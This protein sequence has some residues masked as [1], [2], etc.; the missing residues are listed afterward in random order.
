MRLEI[1]HFSDIHFQKAGNPILSIVDQLAQAVQSVDPAASL[2]LVVVSGDVAYSGSSAE[3]EIAL[4]FFKAFDE[5]LRKFAPTAVVKYVS[6]PGN[7]DCVLPKNG[8]K[9]REALIRGVIPSMREATQDKTLL[10]QL[11]KAQA[12][13]NRFRRRFERSAGWDGLCET[14]VIDHAGKKI[15]LNLYNTAILSQRDESQGN[16]HLPIQA[17]E[18]R[19]SLLK[20]SCVS[21][22]VFHHSY[23]WIESNAAVAF[24]NHVE[25]TSDIALMG[26]QHHAH[27]FYKENSTGERVL[28]L[29][30]PALQDE[31]FARTSS[32]QIVIIDTESQKERSIKFRRSRDLYRSV[33]ET[34]W[35][36]MT[37]NRTVRAQF[38]ANE[39]FEAELNKS[40][41]PLTHRTG[42]LHLRDTFI[43][44]NVLVRPAAN[45][46][47]TQEVNGKELLSYVST[48]RR[49]IFQGVSMSGK[50]ALAKVLFW[51]ILRAG[52]G[53][54]PVLFNGRHAT[55]PIEER[56][57]GEIWS[58]FSSQYDR[59]MLEE[60]KQ[61][62]KEDRVAII[63]DW[64]RTMLNSEGRKEFLNHIS[65]Y[66][67]K[68]IL[69]T[70]ELFQ[71]HEVIS[72]SPDTIIEFD[73]ANILEFGHSLVGRM[74]DKWVT[75][76]R[77]YTGDIRKIR[78]EIESK[79]R[80][81]QSVMGKK[82]LPALPFIV[83]SLLE[84]DEQDKAEAAE[85]GSF[86]Y[87]YEVLV[88]SALSQ[89][90]GPKAQLEKKYNVLARLAY[91]MF[92]MRTH[93][94]PLSTVKEIA[95]EYSKAILVT[96]DISSML[97]DLVEARVLINI[98]GNYS[99]AYS[100]FVYYF[101][102]R[103]YRD[104]LER[105]P[106]LHVEIEKMVDYV[107]SDEYSAILIFLV[108]FAR[109]STEILKRLGTNADMIYSTEA[110]SNLDSDVGFLNQL[111]DHPDVELPE[112]VDVD[113]NVQ[114]QREIRDRVER[115]AMELDNRGKQYIT[116]SEDLSDTDKF[117]LAY[118]H[119]GLLGQV[120]RNFPGSLPGPEKLA[121]LKTTYLLGLRALRALLRM[122]DSSA[123]E[124]RK[125][126]TTAMEEQGEVNPDK[127]NTMVSML[128]LLLSRLCTFSVI[129][130]ISGSVGVAD[131]EAAYQATLE[132]LGKTSAAE[133]IDLSIKLDH[134]DEFP[135]NE[136]RALH[137]KFSDNPFAD[138]ILADLVR[139]RIMVIDVDRRIR[140]SMASIFKMESKALVVAPSK[141]N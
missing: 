128:I 81:I 27:N 129:K 114:E 111:C 123:S 124:F 11:L 115:S 121:I 66:F 60:F 116:Y 6:V 131:L 73:H 38:R 59:G 126:L 4:R 134:T 21:L 94:L 24:R 100:H 89:S 109:G 74:I 84:A 95:A 118:R 120:I 125:H 82:T 99:F 49:L 64:H 35:R 10:N 5:R 33:E 83:L 7:H 130:T 31:K 91:R 40:G 37:I 77:E 56:V 139:T 104:N 140:Q 135:M 51:E 1:V 39:K 138:T 103:Y 72:N 136:I 26:H 20:D 17:F 107:S 8:V 47:R 2:I 32:F 43:F 63:D 133:L 98:D 108:Y 117:D 15:Q 28:Y 13:Y 14:V 119:I 22:S 70:D 58:T 137:K 110:P 23:L 55:T 86:G 75:L 62:S 29:E 90:K 41:L 71:I 44:P 46:R 87:L 34:E 93:T 69:F 48:T 76:G 25:R 132:Q 52:G 3:Y 65:K 112:E 30:A 101:I 122:L 18:D 36:P 54:V 61:L 106:Q 67:D 79:E 80:T 88:T 96:I 127:I 105:D 85:A 50:T 92:K 9:L 12:P 16:L 78:R 19:I 102:A 57:K 45:Q 141:A 53:S 42:N 68:I 113:Q 97:S